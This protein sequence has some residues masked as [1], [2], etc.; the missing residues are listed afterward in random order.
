[1]PIMISIFK[2][3]LDIDFCNPFNYDGWIPFRS[4][5]RMNLPD[6]WEDKIN[7]NYLKSG[8]EVSFQFWSY[9]IYGNNKN[10]DESTTVFFTS[11]IIF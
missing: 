4:S 10:Q 7:S 2:D 5:D 8:K 6:G 1:M 3:N 11:K 9:S